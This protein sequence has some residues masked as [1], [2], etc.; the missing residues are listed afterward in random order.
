MSTLLKKFKF[1]NFF[2]VFF[3]EI[4]SYEDIILMTE[5]NSQL[6][7]MYNTAHLR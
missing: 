6:W 7:I 1:F 4:I 3:I 2:I 5:Q